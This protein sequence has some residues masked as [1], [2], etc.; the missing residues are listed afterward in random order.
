MSLSYEQQFAFQ[1]FKNGNNLF[2]TG[3]GG[4]GKTKLISQLIE[5]S[6]QRSVPYQVC[7]MTGCASVLLNCNART[8]HSW[9]GIKLAKGEHAQIVSGVSK[10]KQV[11]ANWR[12]VRVL[13]IDEISMMSSKIFEVIENIARIAKMSSLPFG[14]IQVIFTGDFYQLPPV[15]NQYEPDS[16][17]FCFESKLWY[18]VFSL[19]NHIQLKTIFRQKDPLYIEILLQIREGN[20]SDANKEILKTYVKRE[21]DI[22]KNNGCI[23]SKIFSVKS[24]VDFV[25]NAMFAKL[26]ESEHEFK[27]IC[28]SDATI[29]ADS[30]KSLSKEQIDNGKKMTVQ[31]V[32]FEINQ[33]IVNTG[34]PASVV[35][36]IGALVMCTANIDMEQSICNGS[37]GVVIDIRGSGVSKIPVVQFS[38]G[39][40]K[41]ID[42]HYIQS[43]DYPN[44]TIAQVPLTLAWAMTI[45]KIQGASMKMAEMDLGNSIFEYGQI[46]VALSRVESLD[47][48]YLSAFHAH[49]IKA[50]PIVKEFYKI[51]PDI[52]IRDIESAS[53]SNS[54]PNIS[55]DV[56]AATTTT[57]VNSTSKN[58]FAKFDYN[59]LSLPSSRELC[60]EEFIIESPPPPKN[61]YSSSSIKIIK[62]HL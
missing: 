4:T 38:N 7:A 48:L 53:T 21:Y 6:K 28:K 62:L 35:L 11:M 12:K 41:S 5:Y 34:I 58:I 33:L 14:G 19:A 50:N 23:P 32:A 29:F 54:S 59:E 40:V 55:S 17:Q 60:A 45:H 25:N 16:N 42:F 56:V 44:I 43:E 57:S 20:I 3:P 10:N 37:H 22:E 26:Q 39:I 27:M 9:S 15:G 61:V 13:I 2:I 47:G 30:G 46:Y 31:Q 8:L 18:S 24:K 49:K 52:V 36:K 51:I 1:K